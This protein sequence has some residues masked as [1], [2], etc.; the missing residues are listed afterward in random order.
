MHDIDLVIGVNDIQARV[1]WDVLIAINNKGSIPT[2]G[3]SESMSNGGASGGGPTNTS[4]QAGWKGSSHAEY[5]QHQLG[6]Y[7]QVYQ[8]SI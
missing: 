7:H 6:L 3:I 5:S 8:S 4:S 1:L 2:K